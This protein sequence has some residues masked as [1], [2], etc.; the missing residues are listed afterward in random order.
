MRL[1]TSLARPLVRVADPMSGFFA[2]QREVF[3]RAAGV[4]PL[5]YK[6]ALELMVKCRPA[7]I[8]EAPITFHCR[9]HGRSKLS[10]RQRMQ[11]LLHIGR[12][13]GYRFFRGRGMF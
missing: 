10:I 2:L 3:E 12:L 13:Y 7:G 1:A 4:E 6:I 9:R 11:F 5:G 8:D